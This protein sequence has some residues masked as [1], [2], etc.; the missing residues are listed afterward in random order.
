MHIE[1]HL[2]V[3]LVAVE[4]DDEVS[5]LIELTAPSAPPPDPAEAKPARTLQIVLDRSGSMSGDRIEGA[6]TALLALVDRLDPTDRFG[7]VAFDDT[8]NLVLAT[9]PLSDKPAAKRAIANVNTGGSTDLS[10]GYL[11]GIQEARRVVGPGGGT[12]LLVSD[13]HANAGVVDPVALG[14]IAAEAYRHGIITSTLGWGL[15]YD[16]RIMSAIARGG[17]G[18]EL[19]AQDSDAAVALIADEVEG[20][21]SQTAQAAS[22]LIGL[23][24][25]VRS[26]RVVNDLPTTATDNG[27]VAELGSFYSGEKRKLLLT[28]DVPAVATLGLVEVAR[29]EFTYV[30]LPALQQHTITVPL[31]VNIVPGDEAA[32]RVAN[33][34]V[35]SEL[36]FQQVQQAKKRASAHLSAGDVTAAMVDINAAQGLVDS[37]RSQTDLPAEYTADLADEDRTLKY[38]SQEAQYG[39]MSSA[40]KYSSM[41]SA[42]SSRHRGRKVP[43]PPPQTPPSP[44]QTPP[45]P[46]QTD[47]NEA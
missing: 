43:P 42:S 6:K 20:L 14:G 4:T 21:L 9:R 25:Y 8:V 12:L 13:G 5:V 18:N 27:I 47:E 24:P 30:E 3:D 41:S 44:P 36:M 37:L 39:S 7:L 26:V 19:F 45:P 23:S 40:A 16:E 1:A 17:S 15:G 2:D 34:T 35:R 33:P 31:H 22:V 11:R 46:Q 38:L 28:F 10:A 32:G 29:L